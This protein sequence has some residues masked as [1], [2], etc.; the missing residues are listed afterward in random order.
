MSLTDRVKSGSLVRR[1][2]VQVGSLSTT[3]VSIGQVSSSHL[4][5]EKTLSQVKTF[6][7][8]PSTDPLGHQQVFGE[9]EKP[10]K[11]QPAR[12]RLSKS[13]NRL[14]SSTSVSRIVESSHQ[15]KKVQ[16]KIPLSFSNLLTANKGSESNKRISSSLHLKFHE[17][18][19]RRVVFELPKHQLPFK[20]HRPL[21][22]SS[23][24]T[25]PTKPQAESPKVTPH[26]GDK[27]IPLITNH[28]GLLESRPS[29]TDLSEILSKATMS[30]FGASISS[31]SIPSEP[32]IRWIVE[33]FAAIKNKCQFLKFGNDPVWKGTNPTVVK[34]PPRTSSTRIRQSADA[35][36][37]LLLREAIMNVVT[38]ACPSQD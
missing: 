34:F 2:T 29:H 21:I 14:P 5:L 38:P 31:K 37:S 3:K 25:S 20:R 24:H 35:K 32:R 10:L 13:S 1:N 16:D 9:G 17:I 36:P 7:T 23:R 12:I 26:P 15:V 27:D 18:L 4:C 8:S 19:Q 6:T 33:D 30:Q 22:C 28:V 11:K